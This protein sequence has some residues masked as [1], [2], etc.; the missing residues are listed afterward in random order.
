[1]GELGLAVDM[2]SL[3]SA[4]GELSPLRLRVEDQERGTL[5]LDI[6][7]VISRKPVEAVG[8]EGILFV[9]WAKMQDSRHMI[10]LR[11]MLRSQTWRLVR[12]RENA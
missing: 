2:I 10:E 6:D 5:R 12:F 3:C 11:Y 9:C 7:R 1:M 4:S 8:A